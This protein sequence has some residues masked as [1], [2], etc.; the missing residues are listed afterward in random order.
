MIFETQ[1][2]TVR[3]LIVEDLDPFHEMQGNPNV[4][5]YTGDRA[6][7]FEED[8]KDL[9]YVI[10]CYDQPENDFWVW[11]IIRKADT[12]FV[13]TCAIVKS[14]PRQNDPTQDEIGYRFLEKYWGNGYGDEITRGLIDFAFNEFGKTELIAEVDE[15]NIAS[16]KILDRH[17]ELVD[18]FYNSRDQSNDRKYI[19]R[20]P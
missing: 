20:K 4:M 12:E 8:Q 2:L 5:K 15:L 7:T 1:R 17:M 13:G 18:R 10:D 16:V 9:Q 6:K 14:D 3:R 19:V 11:A